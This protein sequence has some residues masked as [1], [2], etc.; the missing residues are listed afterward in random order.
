MAYIDLIV[1]LCESRCYTET[2]DIGF[3]CTICGRFTVSADAV[4]IYS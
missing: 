1:R 3:S 2:L 4:C